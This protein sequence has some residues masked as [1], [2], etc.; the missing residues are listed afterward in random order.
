MLAPGLARPDGFT[1]ERGDLMRS[2]V[3]IDVEAARGRALVVQPEE[4]RSWWQPAPANGHADPKLVP[5]DTGFGALSMGFQT[6]APADGVRPHSP[7][8]P[9]RASDLLPGAGERGRG[10]GTPSAEAGDRVLPG[11]GREARDRQ[12]GRRRPRDD[13]ADL[14]G[15]A[16]RF[17][18]HDR[19]RADPRRARPR[20]VRAARGRG[21]RRTRARHERHTTSGR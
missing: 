13:V 7:R 21:R 8:R 9:G 18:P 3:E 15:R 10:R 5:A 14:P 2:K 19:A 4:G 1:S 16:R 6:I 11:P 12:R 20:S 17:L